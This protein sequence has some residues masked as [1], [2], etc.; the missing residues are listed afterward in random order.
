[1]FEKITGVFPSDY[2]S[3]E[4]GVIFL[5]EMKTLGKAIGRKGANINKLKSS[6]RK[7]VIIIGDS[8]DPEMFAKNFFGNLSLI[9]VELREAMGDK[10]IFITVNEKDRGLAIGKAGERIKAAKT[11]FK[12]KFNTSVQLKTK[13]VMDL[14]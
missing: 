1:M 5:V 2:L 8:T 13:R 3:T 6:F 14:S 4:N 7:K 10:T 9:S 11:L 12:K